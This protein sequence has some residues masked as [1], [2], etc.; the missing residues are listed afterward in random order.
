MGVL[1]IFGKRGK[2]KYNWLC[3]NNISKKEKKNTMNPP[4]PVICIIP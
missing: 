3:Y 2:Q 1:V 4:R